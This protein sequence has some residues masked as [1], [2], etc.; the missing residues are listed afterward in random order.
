MHNA[1]QE[2]AALYYAGPEKLEPTFDGGD[3]VEGE[4][5]D[6]GEEDDEGDAGME[7]EEEEAEEEGVSYPSCS[8]TVPGIA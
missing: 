4:E 1:T 8:S 3:E 6:E 7:E 2:C 5:E